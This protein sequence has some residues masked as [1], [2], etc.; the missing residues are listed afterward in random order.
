MIG[1]SG[2]GVTDSFKERLVGG[3]LTVEII[4]SLGNGRTVGSRRIEGRASDTAC[5]S[6]FTS[7]L[8]GSG[9]RGDAKVC[10]RRGG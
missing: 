2:I 1:A 6:G 5:G 8:D 10:G 3:F 9:A 4:R 7:G